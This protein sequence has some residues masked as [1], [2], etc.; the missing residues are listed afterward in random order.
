MVDEYPD[1]RFTLRRSNHNAKLDKGYWFEGE[2]NFIALSFWTNTRWNGN[3][4]KI[5]FIAYLDGRCSLEIQV[6]EHEISKFEGLASD[7]RIKDFYDGKLIKNYSDSLNYSE[8]E[9]ALKQYFF[10]DVKIINKYSELFENGNRFA[11]GDGLKPLSKRVFS[12]M[13]KKVDTHKTRVSELEKDITEIDSIDRPTILQDIRIQNYGPIKD[14]YLDL[15]KRRNNL[16]S[17]GQWVF[18]TGE[19]GSGKSQLLKSIA[20][21]IGYRD[22]KDSADFTVT[23]TVRNDKNQISKLNRYQSDRVSYRKKPLMIGLAMYGPIRL[24]IVTTRIS[25]V[26][27][28]EKLNKGSSFGSLFEPSKSTNSKLLNLHKQ[29]T[30]W[31]EGTDSQQRLFEKRKYFIS[32]LLAQI[33]TNLVSIN[34]PYKKGKVLYEFIGKDQQKY[35]LDW[36]KLSSGNKSTIGMVGDIIIRL[37][38]QQR[39]VIDPADLQGVVIIDEIDLHLH[40]QGQRDLVENLSKA[41]PEVQFIISTHSP[42]PFL[43]APKGSILYKTEFDYSNGV[44]VERLDD[45]L[46]IHDLLP[47]A[48]LTSP[49]FGME[50]IIPTANDLDTKSVR[51]EDDFKD[52]QFNDEVERRLEKYIDSTKEEE[53]IKLFENRNK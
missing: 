41:F 3:V 2:E 31:Q 23:A 16:I 8:I 46:Y 10:E 27:F 53:L 9:K 34:F 28:Y 1:I 12:S 26:G 48:I 7:L 4:P 38:N 29:F 33:I 36:T 42:I 17:N 21:F 24:G 51:T 22:Y 11:V 14:I 44:T 19:N 43:G 20:T 39:S 37:Y 40:P 47:N 35:K 13:V 30:L 6:S 18:I 50:S 15:H 45:K 52:V 5:A 49:I 25:K 32:N